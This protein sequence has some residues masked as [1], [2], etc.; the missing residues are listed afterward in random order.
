M[1]YLAVSDDTVAKHFA[2]FS[3]LDPGVYFV[4][5]YFSESMPVLARS[6]LLTKLAVMRLDGDI[7]ESTVDVLYHLYGH[8]SIG[9]YVII[10]DWTGFP[11]KKACEDFFMVHNFRPLI[12]HIDNIAAY[13]QK[14]EEVEVQFWRYEQK[15]FRD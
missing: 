11:A 4:K 2:S 3:L 9:G 5:G 12:Q 7:Y 8:L 14:T 6:P 1:T 10:D 13:W 15:Q